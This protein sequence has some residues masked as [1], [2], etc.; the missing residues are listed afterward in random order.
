ML[1]PL[2]RAADFHMS[3]R[4]RRQISKG[5]SRVLEAYC[6]WHFYGFVY[7]LWC[8]VVYFSINISLLMADLIFIMA[9]K[10]SFSRRGSLEP[11]T[12]KHHL[13]LSKWWWLKCERKNRVVH[14]TVFFF[15]RT[16]FRECL[17]ELTGEKLES[18]AWVFSLVGLK[19][20]YS[21]KLHP[22]YLDNNQLNKLCFEPG[23]YYYQA[24]LARN[25]ARKR[26]IWKANFARR[27]E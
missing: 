13:H 18:Y 15:Q 6:W 7:C 14:N 4:H 10:S 26:F 22:H 20:C 16:P 5:I 25:H 21:Q 27:V 24:L 3:A 11:Q 17:E 8:S 9:L 1:W 12:Q 2:L 23:Y 19:N